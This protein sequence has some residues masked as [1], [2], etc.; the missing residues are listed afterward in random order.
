MT[1][2]FSAAPFFA[3]AAGGQSNLMQTIIMIAIFILF[4]Y[5]ILFRPER[6][7][8]KA[9]EQQRSSMKKGDRVTAMG[10]VGTLEEIKDTTVIL[11][12]PDGSKVEIVKMAISEV[13]SSS[14]ND[15][16]SEENK[17]K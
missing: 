7:R 5:F 9:L 16:K 1:S 12:N 8:R 15:N 3:L 6:K 2:F 14:S 13:H 17:G 11:K 4:F 10:I